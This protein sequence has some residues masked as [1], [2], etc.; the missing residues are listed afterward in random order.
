MSVRHG[1]LMPPSKY[2]RWTRSQDSCRSD[3]PHPATVAAEPASPATATSRLR[4]TPPGHGRG[5]TSQ[6]S[7]SHVAPAAHPTRPRSRRN[8]HRR[9]PAMP[10]GMCKTSAGTKNGNATAV[11]S[12][13]NVTTTPRS[14]SHATRNHLASSAQLGPVSD[15]APGP[16]G[17]F[18]FAFTGVYRQYRMLRRARVVTF[19]LPS[20]VCTASIGCCAGP[21][22]SAGHR[23]LRSPAGQIY[24]RTPSRGSPVT[25]RCD[26]Q[27]ARYTRAHPVGARRSPAVAIT[28]RPAAIRRTA[29]TDR[30]APRRHYQRAAAIRRTAFTDRQAPR[31]H[32]QRAAAI[33]RTAFTDRQ[34]R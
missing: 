7:H 12:R 21:G 17:H 8:P 27:Q 24:S 18:S 30:Q 22:W 19:P 26:H 20:P 13:T 9:K 15:V 23:P 5:G 2:F 10:A 6:P 33:R 1:C 16:G 11:R 31:R 14:T 34:A 3:A 25:G 28:S 32:Y 4:R 29:F